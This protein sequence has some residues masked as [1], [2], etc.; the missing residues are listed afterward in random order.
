VRCRSSLPEPGDE[1]DE[2]RLI[3]Q[4]AKPRTDLTAMMGRVHGHLHGG[5]AEGRMMNGPVPVL[6][7]LGGPGEPELALDLRLAR[8]FEERARSSR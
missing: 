4:L 2:G 7:E 5:F 6:L 8:R 3:A 1:V